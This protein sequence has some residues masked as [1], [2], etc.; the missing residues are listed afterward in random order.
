MRENP[1]WYN[2]L[3]ENC[4]TVIV[5][6]MAELRLGPR[7]PFDWRYILNGHMDQME[8]ERGNLA[9]TLPFAELK[10]RHINRAA[11]AAGDSPDYSRQIREGRP[12][13]EYII[14]T[15][16]ITEQTVAEYT[17]PFRS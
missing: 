3:T 11:L 10:A 1:R 15:G 6:Q 12:G 16:S 17:Q 13:F 8:Y 2:A 5:Q 14:R 9:G 4:T 7:A